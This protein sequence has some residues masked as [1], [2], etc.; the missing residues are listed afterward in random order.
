MQSNHKNLRRYSYNHSTCDSNGREMIMRSLVMCGLLLLAL[1]FCCMAIAPVQVG[2]ERGQAVLAMI[3]NKPLFHN[4]SDSSD[5]WIWGGSPTGFGQLFPGEGSSNDFGGWAPKG[6][7]PLEHV[8]SETPIGYT[9][10][11]TRHLFSGQGQSW[12][13]DWSIARGE[14]VLGESNR[15]FPKQ[16]FFN[17]YGGWEPDI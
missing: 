16:G 9:I 8:L 5:L 6:E 4:S 7:T 15:L 1:S 2:G 17:G 10:N 12:N 14:N 13:S 11:E 3:A